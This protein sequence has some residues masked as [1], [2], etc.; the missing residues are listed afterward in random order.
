L[1]NALVAVA[2]EDASARP[3]VVEYQALDRSQAIGKVVYV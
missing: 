1:R 2:V 3:L